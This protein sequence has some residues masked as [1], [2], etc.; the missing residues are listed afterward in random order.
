M[1]NFALRLQ[2]CRQQKNQTQKEAAEALG[3]SERVWRS[4]ESGNR[5]PTFQGLLKLADYFGVS[6]DY[7][8][9]R[10]DKTEINR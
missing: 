9:G 10:A 4:Y 7:L 1:S 5:T 2:E 6:L 3:F 8:V